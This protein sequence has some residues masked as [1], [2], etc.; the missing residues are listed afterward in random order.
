MVWQHSRPVNPALVKA[1]RTLLEREWA[2]RTDSVSRVVVLGTSLT[3]YGVNLPAYFSQRTG[4]RCRL[5]TVTRKGA[6]L[7]TFTD[8]TP[9][10]EL[11]DRYPPDVLC[12]EENLLFLDFKD[13]AVIS[14][15]N[16][17][18]QLMESVDLAKRR[19]AGARAALT[20]VAP[21][22]AAVR[23]I[24]FDSVHY[25]QQLSAIGQ[26]TVR[27]FAP[28]HALHTYLRELRRRGT[29]LVILHFPRPHQL[30]QAIYSGPAGA[31][32]L[33]CRQQYQQAYQAAY[34]HEPGAYPFAYF[35]DYAHLNEKG[36]AVYS[37]WLARQLLAAG[38]KPVGEGRA[39]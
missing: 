2:Q 36:Q 24:L 4:G 9:I 8:A 38:Q 15:T 39:R 18:I 3:D 17:L 20:G 16:V 34:W 5:V 28:R 35:R 26:R 1:A 32:L 25:E 37:A 23:V 30:E 12:I 13:N 19:L 27:D 6:N 7:E 21:D 33:A 22:T 11:L 29:R 10:F 14:P 31:A